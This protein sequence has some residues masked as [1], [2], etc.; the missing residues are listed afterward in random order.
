[1]TPEADQSRAVVRA[2]RGILLLA[3]FAVTLALAL[4]RDVLVPFALSVVFA[5]LLH[6]V[7]R[8]LRRLHLPTPA[9]AAIVVTVTLAILLGL[10]MLIQQPLQKLADEAPRGVAAARA[11]LDEI[12]GRLRRVSQADSTT[13]P[14]AADSSRAR[15]DSGARRAPA[16]LPSPG[17]AG[18][19]LGGGP[20]GMLAHAIG[21][22]TSLLL[23]VVEEILLMFFMLAAG[24]SWMEKL[25]RLANTSSGARLWPA[26]AGDMH[27]VVARYLVVNVLINGGQAVLIGLALWAIGFPSPLL[28][29]ALTFV[30]EFIPYLGGL[31][32][33][34]LL[35]IAGVSM[36]KGLAPA[37]VGPAIY[38]VVTTL[39]NNLVSPLAYGKGLRLNPTAI[40][41]GVMFFWMIWGIAGAFLAVPILAS[42]RVLGSR[43][44]EWE[45]MAVLLEE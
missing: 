11:K 31:T 41:V 8:R 43:V 4:G 42:L 22:T 1:M 44:P 28:W 13:S 12:T 34:A 9:A 38:L 30:A 33:M 14:R 36:N 24:D 39:Q 32:M 45:P 16:P 5:T 17:G 18:G 19:L 29:G 2:E 26:I 35:F 27:D 40:L 25:R 37:L 15:A 3:G 10:G 23:E 20:F 21:V 7:V 6:P